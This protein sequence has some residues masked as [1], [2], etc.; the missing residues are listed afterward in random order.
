M[1]TCM[2]ACMRA[3]EDKYWPSH[4]FFHPY[5]ESTLIPRRLGETH[6]FKRIFIWTEM[7]F[8]MELNRISVDVVAGRVHVS[9]PVRCVIY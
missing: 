2:R 7:N 6:V 9:D 3:Q 8:D 1:H 4:Q 5:M